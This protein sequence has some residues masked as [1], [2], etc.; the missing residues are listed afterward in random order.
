MKG[1]PTGRTLSLGLVTAAV[2]AALS[3]WFSASA[4]V[5]ALRAQAGLDG[6]TASLFSSAVQIG[7]VCGTV[8]SAILVLADRFDPRRLFA[9][10]AAVAASANLAIL[11]VEPASPVVILCRFVTGACMAGIYPV[12]MKIMTTWAKAEMGLLVGLL[13][14]AVTLGSAAPHLFNGLAGVDWQA[15]LA[16]SSVAAYAAAILVLFAG[17]G[18]NVGKTPPFRPHYALVA[19]RTRAIR[20]A[21]LGY[22]GHMW[23]LYAMWSWIGVFLFA[24]FR[25]SM[26]EDDALVS[27]SLATFGVVG[28]G[29]VGCVLAGLWADRAGRTAVTMACMAASGSC[30]LIVGFLFGGDPVWLVAVCL[31]WGF[32][33]VADSAQFSAS[34]A[35]LSERDLVG[36]ML[37][38]QTGAGFLLT[39]ATI[40][41]MPPLVEWLGWRYAFAFLAIG[42]FLGI[43]AMA[44]LRALPEAVKLAGGKR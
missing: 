41:L 23:E 36:T 42:P 4:I 29:A 2:V 32:T 24:S 7:F 16:I 14:G 5:P 17:I 31:L 3:L 18:P 19:W 43:L 33:I 11:L 37:T 6:L 38:V 28:A 8:T 34:T 1:M 21:N 9:I 39:L 40:H 25:L 10:S 35:E 26:A 30:A 22:L 20:Y 27:A 13:V 12:G 15:T 44:R